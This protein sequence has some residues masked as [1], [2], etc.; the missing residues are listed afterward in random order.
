MCYKYFCITFIINNNNNNK[1]FISIS[2][3][4]SLKKKMFRDT[5]DQNRNK[6]IIKMLLFNYYK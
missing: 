5:P 1:S 6:I 2:C 4:T 3:G